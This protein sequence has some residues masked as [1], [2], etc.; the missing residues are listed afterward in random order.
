MKYLKLYK[1]KDGKLRLVDFGLRKFADLYTKQGYIVV[2][3]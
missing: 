1:I 3:P 2:Y